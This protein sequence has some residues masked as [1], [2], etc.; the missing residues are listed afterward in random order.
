MHPD[1]QFDD[2]NLMRAEA[3]LLAHE[4]ARDYFQ[5]EL[6]DRHNNRLQGMTLERQA[7]DVLDLDEVTV[8]RLFMIPDGSIVWALKVGENADAPAG[9]DIQSSNPFLAEDE[10]NSVIAFRD[11]IGPAMWLDALYIRRLM[12]THNAPERLAT[13]SFGLMAI[14][15]Y[16]L[17]FQHISLFAAGM[18]PLEPND[19]DSFIGYDVWPKFGFD[20]PVIPAELN[21]FPIRELDS[22]HTVQEVIAAAPGWWAAH[23][24]GR[25]MQF[26]LTA[27]SRSWNV[28]LNYLYEALQEQQP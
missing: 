19:P 26:D 9:L 2:Q 22:A 15:A 3:I 12:L 20:A 7:G 24:T 16:R 8:G 4:V 11:E 14:T 10:T 17:G 1:Q 25:R 27:G 18:G 13:V 6:Y 21:R 23:G 28:L 5:G